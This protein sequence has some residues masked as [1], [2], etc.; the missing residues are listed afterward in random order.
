LASAR[1]AEELSLLGRG[2]Q[3]RRRGKRLV[4]LCL[5]AGI[6]VFDS[7]DVYSNG[8]SEEIFGQAI[9]GRRHEVLISTK[10]TFPFGKRPQLFQQRRAQ[11]LAETS[12]AK[13]DALPQAGAAT[14]FAPT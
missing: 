13:P 9:Q 12:R 4:G 8:L 7:A 1:S 14:R 2:A 3:Q 11:A 5:D 6:N 10:A